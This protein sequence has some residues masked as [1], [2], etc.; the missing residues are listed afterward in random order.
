MKEDKDDV[1]YGPG[2]VTHHCG[3]VFHDDRN[4]CRFFNVSAGWMGSCDKVSG[5]IDRAYGCEL[6]ER[7]KK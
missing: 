1:K 2:H 4:Y 5:A 7:V 6:F 3:P